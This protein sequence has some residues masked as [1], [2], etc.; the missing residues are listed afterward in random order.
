MITKTVN[1]L[2][3]NIP[4]KAQ[5]KELKRG[6][7]KYC[8]RKCALTVGRNKSIVTNKTAI[9]MKCAWCD[10]DIEVKPSRLKAIKKGFCFC[11]RKCKE[12]GQSVKGIKGAQPSHYGTTHCDYRVLARNAYPHK[13]NNCSYDKKVGI[14]IVHHKDRNRENNDVS[15]LE[16]LCPNCH[17]E[18]HLRNKDGIFW[19][20]GLGTA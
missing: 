13:C 11:S 16:I 20:M 9:K 5:V 4:F 7:G 1:C 15:N 3:C 12:V 6:N 10:K 14:L 17:A 18:E 2:L 8:S 19:K